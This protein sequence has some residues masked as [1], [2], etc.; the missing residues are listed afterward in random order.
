[1]NQVDTA[2]Q[3][4]QKNMNHL[5][6]I[7]DLSLEDITF[8]FQKAKEYA[9]LLHNKRAIDPVL[10]GKVLINL[11]FENSTRTR[12][13][14]ELAIKKLGGD[15]INWN[16]DTSSLNKGESFNDTIQTLNAMNPDAVII[17]HSE[18][19]A[20]EYLSKHMCCPV[21]NAGDSWREHPSQALLDAFTIKE[22]FGDIDGLT[23]GICG[24]IAHSRVAH[25]NI[26]LLTK[27]G[28]TLHII[29]PEQLM[30]KSLNSPSVKT[31]TSLKDGLNSCSIIMALRIQKERLKESLDISDQQYHKDFGLTE[32]SLKYA[33]HDI[34]VMHPGPMNRGIEISD[35][36]ADDP[37][38]SLILKQVRNGVPVRMAI[39]ERVINS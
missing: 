21:I 33:T 4:L 25:S 26:N 37:E 5:T 8:I 10:K 38:R 11:F 30:P 9:H 3:N 13:S 7:N 29:A 16:S 19:G 12:T 32:D 39:L 18:Y 24:D 27:L 23:I 34:K 2:P 31:F 36:I 1:M 17:R 35:V 28:A 15:V 14:F 20:P 6:E 22:E